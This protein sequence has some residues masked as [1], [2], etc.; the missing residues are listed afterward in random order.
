MTN[1]AST[2]DKPPQNS[3]PPTGS[4]PTL[5]LRKK[6]VFAMLPLLVLFAAMEVGLRIAGYEGATADPYASFVEHRPLFVEDGGTMRTSSARTRFFHDQRFAMPKPAGTTRIFVFGGS[7]TYGYGLTDPASDSYVARVEAATEKQTGG[8]YELINCGGI[9]YASYRLVKLVEESLH[10]EPDMLIVMSGHNEFLE[11]RHYG[12][13]IARRS[14]RSGLGSLRTVQL[15]GDLS[16]RAAPADDLSRTDT[17]RDIVLAEQIE[18]RY[19]V[20]DAAEIDH[21]IEHYRRNVTRMVTACRS[22]NV[23][24][25]LCTPASNLRDFPPFVTEAKGPMANSEMTAKFEEARRLFAA[26]E[27]AKTLAL[28]Q[29]VLAVDDRAAAFDFLA[30]RSLDQLKRPNEAATHYVRARDHDG[31]PHRAVSALIDAVRDIASATNAPLVDVEQAFREASPD[32]IPGNNLFLDQCH[33]NDAGHELIAGALVPVIVR[34]VGSPA[35][36]E[37]E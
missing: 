24:I 11:P 23:P 20:R 37:S 28:S 26:G 12:D 25:V 6:L 15:I 34:T 9:S 35:A 10:Y 14:T 8:E 3:E 22:A 1:T 5:P 16:T 7:V 13:I 33:P 32:G 36:Q 19:I 21:T 30:A 31:F 18:E 17:Q 2:H 29:T 4:G 27:Y